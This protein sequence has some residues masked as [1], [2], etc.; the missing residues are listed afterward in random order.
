[1]TFPLVSVRPGAEGFLLCSMSATNGHFVAVVAEDEVFLLK[2]LTIKINHSAFTLIHP[3][4]K[5][6]KLSIKHILTDITEL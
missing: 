3:L 6:R 4:D 2:L 1:M 5:G